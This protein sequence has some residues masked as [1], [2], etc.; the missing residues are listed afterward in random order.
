MLTVPPI[1]TVTRC[2]E[3]TVTASAFAPVDELVVTVEELLTSAVI[4]DNTSGDA[5]PTSGAKFEL[6]KA[7]VTVTE[8][9]GVA[10][11]VTDPAFTPTVAAVAIPVQVSAPSILTVQA[12]V[13]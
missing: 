3:S 13:E 7:T 12:V 1:F 6:V 8:E 9:P 11:K 2:V 5:S 4:L 10:L